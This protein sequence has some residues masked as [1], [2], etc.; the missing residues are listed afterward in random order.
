MKKEDKD[1]VFVIA[2]F[3][4][5]VILTG[6]MRFTIFKDEFSHIKNPAI[7]TDRDLLS[8][9]D[10]WLN[11]TNDTLFIRAVKPNRV[12]YMHKNTLYIDSIKHFPGVKKIK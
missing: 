5:I 8:N 6:I 3:V 7:L 10:V 9:G 12:I 1:A 2:I 4:A 11:D